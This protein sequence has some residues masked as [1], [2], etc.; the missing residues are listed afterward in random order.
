MAKIRIHKSTLKKGVVI[1]EAA[2]LFPLLLLLMLGT[3]EYG[4]LFLK[5][6]QI[7]N[8]ARQG[9]RVA[10]RADATSEQ[11]RSTIESLMTSAGMGDS[12]YQVIITP[13]DISSVVPCAAVNVK[14]MVPSSEILLINAPALLPAPTN[15]QANVTMSKEGP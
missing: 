3:I 4:W 11:V 8:A 6:Q 10:I 2:L 7:T 5:S 13:S 1:V 15:L 9:A 14:V 12:G